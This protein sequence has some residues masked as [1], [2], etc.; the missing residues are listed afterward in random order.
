MQPNVWV[1][2][3]GSGGTYDVL[4]PTSSVS[5]G[6]QTLIQCF[7][8]GGYVPSYGLGTG[9]GY[10][11]VTLYVYNGEPTL[12]GTLEGTTTVTILPSGVTFTGAATG[13][14]TIGASATYNF[15]AGAVPSY[16]ATTP[17]TWTISNGT[18]V[19]VDNIYYTTSVSGS[20]FTITPEP[21]A[22]LYNGVAVGAYFGAGCSVNQTQEIY[23]SGRTPIVMPQSATL[24]S[25]SVLLTSNVATTTLTPGPSSPLNS[26]PHLQDVLLTQQWYNGSGAIAGATNSSFTATAPGTYFLKSTEQDLVYNTTLGYYVWGNPIG[27]KTSNSVTILPNPGPVAASF[28][29][30][31]SA[32]TPS[33]TGARTVFDCG[34]GTLAFQS[35]YTGAIASYLV[36]AVNQSTSV[37]ST[38]YSGTTRPPASLDVS[39][40]LTGTADYY[41]TV[42]ISN[43][44]NTQSYSGYIY[45]VDPNTTPMTATFA[46]SGNT[47]VT[48]TGAASAPASAP[49]ATAA[50]A[51]APASTIFGCGGAITYNTSSSSG[52]IFSYQLSIGMPPGPGVPSATVYSGLGAPPST[53]NVT[54]AFY[55]TGTY[56]IQLALSNGCTTTTMS[57]YYYY[58]DAATGSSSSPYYLIN[59]ALPSSTIAGAASYSSCSAITLDAASAGLSIWAGGPVYQYLIQLN[60]SSGTIASTGFSTP[61]TALSIAGDF[62]SSGVQPVA[63]TVSNGCAT[64]SS[65]GYLDVNVGVPPTDVI[66]TQTN[67]YSEYGA[68]PVLTTYPAGSGSD[69][70]SPVEVG[71]TSTS[72]YIDPS[73]GT[74]A[75]A[76]SYLYTIYSVNSSGATT[77]VWN[78]SSIPTGCSG[79]ALIN[80]PISGIDEIF[81]P[82][83][84]LPYNFFSSATDA[85]DYSEWYIDIASTNAC[86]TT[87]NGQFFE[88]YPPTATTGGYLRHSNNSQPV[89]ALGDNSIHFAPMPFTSNVT[90]QLNLDDD[91]TTSLSIVT[92]D[93]RLISNTWEN[94]AM[95]KGSTDITINTDDWK[96]GLYFYRF[97]VNGKQYTGKL[98]KQ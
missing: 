10:G 29:F 98:V 11:P 93:G 19:T 36:T 21:L 83:P 92:V 95:Q 77:Y 70:S 25:G 62:T 17:L 27:T 26:A 23:P 7:G 2:E 50:A 39:A 82:S 20:S 31:G 48:I 41:V 45:V 78:S 16:T 38:L 91:A 66:E 80:I 56:L 60:P 55:A 67:Y 22:P 51:L 15:N 75:S 8:P 97:T 47:P 57:E 40:L 53:L 37:S 58:Y 12:G 30:N 68:S 9:A 63:F 76:C 32:L 13:P 74:G 35:S 44:C 87:H 84:A 88:I 94:Q 65:T 96:P 43:A 64:A 86:G 33:A 71:R 1:Y 79:G 59:G 52:P 34:T 85:P 49:A 72:F 61:P 69:Y 90:A 42:S 28:T 46:V 3:Y 73:F 14:T 4:S 24:C 18:G 5:Y 89:T 54:S 81:P 6:T